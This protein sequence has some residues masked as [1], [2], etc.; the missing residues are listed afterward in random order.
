MSQ[1][2]KVRNEVIQVELIKETV[3]PPYHYQEYQNGFGSAGSALDEEIKGAP[4][5]PS[6]DYPKNT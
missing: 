2:N 6:K 5:K 4:D 1:D 3:M